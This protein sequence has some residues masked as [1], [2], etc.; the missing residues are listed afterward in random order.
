MSQ[1]SIY[2]K[3]ELIE[4]VEALERLTIAQEKANLELRNIIKMHQYS[5][6][7]DRLQ[8]EELIEQR[9]QL[10]ECVKAHLELPVTH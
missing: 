4:K 1:F 8:I 7:L 10:Y 6:D 3:A 9:N 2:S 5:R